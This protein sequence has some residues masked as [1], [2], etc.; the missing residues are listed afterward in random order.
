MPKRWMRTAT[1]SATGFT[2]LS[3]LRSLAMNALHL[4]GF[5]S[6][7]KRLAALAHAISGLPAWLGWLLLQRASLRDQAGCSANCSAAC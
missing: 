3:T 7:S 6:I 4:D 5:W 2:I 1:A